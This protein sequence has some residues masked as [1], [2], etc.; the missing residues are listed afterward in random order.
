MSKIEPV[1]KSG[2]I[3]GKFLWDALSVILVT[4]SILFK[5]LKNILKPF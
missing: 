2:I 1:D 4:I 5:I 3:V